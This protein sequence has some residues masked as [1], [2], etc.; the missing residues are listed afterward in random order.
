[1]GYGVKGVGN[2]VGYEVLGG[3]WLPFPVRAL[4]NSVVLRAPKSA[5]KLRS[6]CL[7]RMAASDRSRRVGSI[8]D[9]DAAASSG[10][11]DGVF[12][13]GGAAADNRREGF[14]AESVEVGLEMSLES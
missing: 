8:F 6:L 10:R 12:R 5:A 14:S 7:T 3:G 13:V 2:G 9:V 11:A 4:E 1:M